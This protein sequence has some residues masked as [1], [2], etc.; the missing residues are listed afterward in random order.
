MKYS[1]K[2]L[3]T[4][5]LLKEAPLVIQSRGYWMWLPSGNGKCGGVVR[6]ECW[7]QLTERSLTLFLHSYCRKY[8]IIMEIVRCVETFGS[9]SAHVHN[10]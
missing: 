9:S 8:R 3:K 4:R 1:S 5:T 6:N 10:R 7:W 2:G